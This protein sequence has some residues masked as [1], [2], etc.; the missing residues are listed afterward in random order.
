MEANNNDRLFSQRF[1]V[2]YEFSV[3]FTRDV[4]SRENKTL[5]ELIT[6]HGK[7]ARNLIAVVID[8][9]VVREMPD[10]KRR[11]A[12][13]VEAW[14]EL[15]LAGI[16]ALVGGEASK[17]DPELVLGLQRRFVEY[18]LDRHS[19]VV[20]V[21]GG[22]VLDVVGYAAATTH[23]GIRHIRVPTTVLAQNDSGVGVKNGINAFGMKNMLGTFVPPFA[24]INDSAFI[25]VLPGRDK[26]AGMAEAV[27]V[28]LI[29]DKEFF[30]WLEEK[31][32]AL[33]IFASEPLDKL[34]RHCALLHMRQI[35]HGGDP[36]ERGSVRPLDFGHWAAH[37]LEVLSDYEL[38]HGEAVAIG[39]AL[40]T[41]YSVLA[42]LLPAGEDLRVARL[43]RR[44]GF[45]L[46]HEAC[47]RRDERGCRL[48]LNGLEEFREH[49]GGELTITLLSEVGV[50]I[51]VHAMDAGMIGEAL[52]WLRTEAN[53]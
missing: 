47:D 50:G 37:K 24:V 10:I 39:I 42:G 12:A 17:N 19:Y 1:S 51:E 15:T 36:F 41:R 4:F 3:A 53:A 22:A 30:E 33:A 14:P 20:C 5:F 46:W 38:R 34:I 40:D 43:L 11:I 23:R 35:A 29:R 52:D 26:R 13:Y 25:D 9:S 28:A 31:A 21:G 32:E 49:L 18:G 48:L 44:L 16:D 45:E 2:A 6:E 27:K 8:E 7:S